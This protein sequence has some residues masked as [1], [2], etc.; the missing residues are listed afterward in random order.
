MSPDPHPL[1]L[2]C[3]TEVI[4]DFESIDLEEE[5]PDEDSIPTPQAA[6]QAP[7]DASKERLARLV[8][9]I[10]RM[11]PTRMEILRSVPMHRMVQ[12]FGQVFWASAEREFFHLSQVTEFYDEFLSHS[13]QVESWK[14]VLLLITLKNGA[15]ACVMGTLGAAIMMVLFQLDFLPGFKKSHLHFQWSFWSSAVGIVLALMTLLFWRPRGSV[16]VDRMCIN[17]FDGRMK[18][19]GIMNIGAILKVSKSLLVVWDDSYVERLWCMFE[20]AAF[21]KAHPDTEKAAK[22]VRVQPVQ[23]GVIVLPISL[24]FAVLGI[25]GIVNPAENVLAIWSILLV[26]IILAGLFCCHTLRRYYRSLEATNRRLQRFELQKAFCWCCSVNHINPTTGQPIAMCDREIVRQCVTSWYGSEKEFDRSVRTVVATA[27]KQQLGCDAL[28]YGWILGG[29]SSFLW[30][31]L[32]L[33]ASYYRDDLVRHLVPNYVIRFAAYWLWMIPTVATVG[34]FLA[35]CFRAQA[36]SKLG[37]FCKDLLVLV[38]AVPTVLAFLAWQVYTELIF[39][40]SGHETWGGLLF[41]A[42]AL[43]TFVAARKV[44]HLGNRRFEDLALAAQPETT[45]DLADENGTGESALPPVEHVAV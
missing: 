24:L 41:A 30:P 10:E 35:R 45:A 14:K 18:A 3:L 27:L 40:H 12:C 29:T 26:M 2:F 36:R 43:I 33:L 1:I 17:Q 39:M 25:S 6:P 4:D 21:L 31:L 23:L 22:L 13:W 19:E 8:A 38:L 16:F 34:L 15:P 42:A 32:D 5:V 11:Q 20:M 9:I 37:D 7:T 44:Y 28:P